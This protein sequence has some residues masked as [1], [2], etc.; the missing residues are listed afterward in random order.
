MK[1]A[2]R[3]L[4]IPA[5]FLAALYFSGALEPLLSF[6]GRLDPTDSNDQPMLLAGLVFAA[7]FFITPI[8]NAR[9][10]ARKQQQRQQ[11]Q[12]QRALQTPQQQASS[13]DK[14]RGNRIQSNR[15]PGLMSILGGGFGLLFSG[16]FAL[17]MIPAEMARGNDW[18]VLFLAV[19]AACGWM[20]IKGIL[21]RIK[22]NSGPQ[23]SVS[24]TPFPGQVGGV[25][26]GQL[27]LVSSYNRNNNSPVMAMSRRYSANLQLMKTST[28]GSG[29]DRRTSTAIVSEKKAETRNEVS[30]D[31]IKVHFSF[32]IP[33]GFPESRSGNG[34]GYWYQV[35][36]SSSDNEYSNT[37]EVPVFKTTDVLDSELDLNT[38][39]A[40]SGTEPAPAVRS[41]MTPI[42][43]DSGTPS[44]GW[45]LALMGGIFATVGI[46]LSLV[47]DAPVIFPIVFTPVGLLLLALGI[48][49]SITRYHTVFSADKV[50]QTTLIL[51]KA[52]EPRVWQREQLDTLHLVSGG[53][54][55]TNGRMTEYYQLKLRTRDGKDLHI[56]FGI[57]GREPALNRMKQLSEQAGLAISYDPVDRGPASKS[58]N[59]S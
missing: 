59:N 32:R 39:D 40:G 22:F 31:G 49:Q 15:S 55:T 26:A 13:N 36:F 10:R 27:H 24:L 56:E 46:A 1:S 8:W 58:F 45:M 57:K 23:D 30:S 18:I 19:P 52:G 28:S 29:K 7:L 51:G 48:K 50:S 5:V 6:F 34:D 16:M 11:E 9:R 12:Q 43:V 54:A 53:S 41:N 2:I 3:Q 21:T 44:L 33:K 37:F 35:A 38:S 42:T 17:A 4:L 25:V 14:W 20:V 47:S